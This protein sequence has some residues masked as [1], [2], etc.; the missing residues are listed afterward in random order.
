MNQNQFPMFKNYFITSL[1]HIGKSKMNFAFKLGGLSLAIFSFLAIAI[2]VAFQLSFD[3]YHRDYQ[4]IY[5]VNTQRIENGVIENYA[6]TPHALGPILQQHI[7]EIVSMTRIRHANHTY[8]R[9]DKELFDCEGMLEADSSLFNVLTFRF[10]KGNN[11]ALRKSNSIVLT[12]TMAIT[13]FGTTDVLQRTL[14]INNDEKPFEITAVVEDTPS[15]SHLF[16]NAIIR[17]QDKPEFSLSSIADPVVFVDEASTLFVRLSQSVGETF[18]EKIESAL[19]PY[20]GKS[21]RNEHGFNVSFQPIADVY[22]GQ[23]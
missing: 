22:L 16:T 5:R 13:L 18:N 7:P 9:I 19:E 6:I 23:N 15:N 8:L 1:R 11:K 3:T 4:N 12:N 10:I 20:I 14:R 2:Y 21:Q 17:I